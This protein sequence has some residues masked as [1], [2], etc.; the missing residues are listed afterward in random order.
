M[1]LYV[2]F[3]NGTGS[4]LPKIRA[5]GL[6]YAAWQQTQAVR[7]VSQGGLCCANACWPVP[8]VSGHDGSRLPW[9][10]DIPTAGGTGLLHVRGWQNSRHL[11]VFHVALGE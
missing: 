6:S 10:R 1:L 9:L 2:S 8:T 3:L 7:C 11:E 5:V 4:S